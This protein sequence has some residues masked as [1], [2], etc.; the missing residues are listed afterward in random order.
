MDTFNK[1]ERRLG[2]L[3]LPNLTMWIM[4]GQIFVFGME[5]LNQLGTFNHFPI[6]ALR[7]IPSKVVQGEVWRLVTFIFQTPGTAH[8]IW[9]IFVWGIFF[10][11]GTALE[12]SWGDFKYNLFIWTYILANGLASL[13]ILFV[14]RR[15][16]VVPNY[17]LL[18]T[19]FL[20]FAYLNPNI[21]FRLYFVLPVKVKWLGMVALAL[22]LY[23][24]AFGDIYTRIIIIAALANLVIFL[25]KDICYGL[26]ARQRR[27]VHQRRVAHAADEAFH[28]CKIC[29]AT[30]KSHPDRDFFYHEGEGYCD[31]CANQMPE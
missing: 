23:Q 13:I 2:K 28:T 5:V 18:Q 29:G 8:P 3:T 21:E 26:K 6:E 24:F 14:L 9:L 25:G 30:E 12:Q 10:L 27:A 4:V 7:L 11:T 20:A 17:F 31:Q 16:V 1:L 19:V 22:L 15:D